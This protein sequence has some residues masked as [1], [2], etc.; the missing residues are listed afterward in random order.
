VSFDSDPLK[1]LQVEISIFEERDVVGWMIRLRNILMQELYAKKKIRYQVLT[2][3]FGQSNSHLGKF[4][5][6]NS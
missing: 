1:K 3:G 5:R 2:M 4:Y 6:G